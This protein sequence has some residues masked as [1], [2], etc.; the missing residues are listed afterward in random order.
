MAQTPARPSAD[1]IAVRL[2]STMRYAAFSCNH[3][4]KF[5]QKRQTRLVFLLYFFKVEYFRKGKCLLNTADVI[6]NF[7]LDIPTN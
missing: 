5:A 3:A 1:K 6:V 2:L 4:Q 7:Q